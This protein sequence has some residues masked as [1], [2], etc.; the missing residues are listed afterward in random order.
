MKMKQPPPDKGENEPWTQRE[1]NLLHEMVRDYD[2]ARW[3]KGQAKWWAVWLL[4]LPATVLM[5]WE[6]VA[7]LW[8]LLRG[9]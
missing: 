1:L 9:L 3:L 7:R 2:R 4:G 6:P 5:V 8:K